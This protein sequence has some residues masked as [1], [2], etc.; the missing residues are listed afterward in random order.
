MTTAEARGG[1]D[2]EGGAGGE[3]ALAVVAAASKA[4]PAAAMGATEADKA[5]VATMVAGRGTRRP[6]KNKSARRNKTKSATA[7]RDEA[8]HRR[9]SSRQQAN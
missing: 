4:A 7:S 9:G 3:A 5:A 2:T 1:T 8:G 6:N